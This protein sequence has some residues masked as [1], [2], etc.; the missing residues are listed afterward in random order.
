MAFHSCFP[1]EMESKYVIQMSM[2]SLSLRKRSNLFKT[3][4]KLNAGKETLIY[5]YTFVLIEQSNQGPNRRSSM[6]SSKE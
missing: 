1:T 4:K 6:P 5:N 2:S 3:L